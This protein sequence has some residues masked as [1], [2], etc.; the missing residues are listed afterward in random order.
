MNTATRQD[1]AKDKKIPWYFVAFFAGLAVLNVIFVTIAVKSYPGLVT[2]NAY[3][4]GLNY[5]D[6]IDAKQAQDALGWKTD[7]VIEND[8]IILTLKD[9]NGHSIK[10]A[11]ITASLGRIIHE[12]D[13]KAVTFIETSQGTYESTEKFAIK[14]RW[15]IRAQITWQ[16][17][18]IQ[19]SENVAAQ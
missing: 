18:Q 9:K 12:H 19:I 11:N 13:D 1:T 5:N 6:M 3:E 4:K 2:Q 17:K 14:G 8:R 10:G 7:F 16:Q 15:N